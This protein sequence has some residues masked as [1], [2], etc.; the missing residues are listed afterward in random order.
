MSSVWNV[1]FVWKRRR[2]KT[3]L[4]I[5]EQQ[6]L[7]ILSAVVATGR[8][9]C[10]RKIFPESVSTLS[11]MSDVVFNTFV[12]LWIWI[13]EKSYVLHSVL[14]AHCIHRGSGGACVNANQSGHGYLPSDSTTDFPAEDPEKWSWNNVD[15]LTWGISPCERLI[16]ILAH[17]AQHKEFCMLILRRAGLYVEHANSANLPLSF[18]STRC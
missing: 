4:L 9:C 15:Y 13:D 18:S 5:R 10:R 14:K 7:I 3:F 17:K 12:C 8:H 16:E 6:N 11:I 2:S 1:P